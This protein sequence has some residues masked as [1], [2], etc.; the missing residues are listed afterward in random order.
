ME[1]RKQII[2]EFCA[3]PFID[4][5]I[6]ALKDN[7]SLFSVDLNLKPCIKVKKNRI[8]SYY[9]DGLE[10]LECYAKRDTCNK[11]VDKFIISIIRKCIKKYAE[12][13]E[14]EPTMRLDSSSAILSELL[15]ILINR[16]E[17]CREVD[18]LKFAEIFLASPYSHP[19]SL[20]SS[21]NKLNL[22]AIFNNNSFFNFYKLIIE[23]GTI[24]TECLKFL[25][26]VN[27]I[28]KETGFLFYEYS[29]NKIMN[30]D[31]YALCHMGAFCS[32]PDYVQYEFTN[33]DILV[34]WFK[35]SSKYI[36]FEQ[37]QKDINSFIKSDKY[38]LKRAGL[39]LIC[40]NFRT[41]KNI[42]YKNI[43]RFINDRDFYS[44]L[45]ELININLDQLNIE[46]VLSK[47]EKASFGVKNPTILKNHIYGI[48]KKYLDSDNGVIKQT[49][50]YK[51]ETVKDLNTIKNINRMIYFVEDSKLDDVDMLYKQ[52]KDKDPIQALDIYKNSK[53]KSSYY[54]EVFCDAYFQLIGNNY[55]FITD[56]LEK[57][58]SRMINQILFKFENSE[59][60]LLNL[61][62]KFIETLNDDSFF[63][64]CISTVLFRLEKLCDSKKFNDVFQMLSKIDYRKIEIKQEIKGDTYISDLINYNMHTYLKMVAYCAE[65]NTVY[66]SFLKDV[67]EYLLKVVVNRTTKALISYIMTRLSRID[68]N[69]CRSILD[70]V[71]DNT[72][73]SFNP[74]F[75]MYSISNDID[76]KLLDLIKDRDDFKKYIAYE[77]KNGDIQM[78]QKIIFS[79]LLLLA[80]KQK[81]FSFYDD[82]IKSN[83]IDCLNNGFE[84]IKYWIINNESAVEI[85]DVVN[86]CKLVNLNFN[87]F[88][89][90]DK[91]QID[92][93]IRNISDLLISSKKLDDENVW[94]LY[95][96]LFKYFGDYFSDETISVLK[97]YKTKRK[98]YI[99]KIM[100][101]YV[102]S[103][104]QYAT[105]E[106]TLIEA[107]SIFENDPNYSVELKRWK[108]MINNKNPYFFERR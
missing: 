25:A 69:Y 6:L 44:D 81:N 17:Y 45:K 104:E 103:Y 97:E 51:T 37:L 59:Q 85:N 60:K 106:P 48:L 41:C 64:D 3:S 22:S 35:E 96:T 107:L 74:S 7:E 8:S 62:Q 58:D 4:K 21:L 73:E 38:F 77:T 16:P 63:D 86:F 88:K 23:K 79:R 100:R 54:L 15:Q 82:Y 92:Q 66:F 32:Y 18:F 9:W 68:I 84:N 31:H 80:F 87:K 75:L 57:F 105:Y 49:I 70:I 46:L 42:F 78:S 40:I 93:L 43:D 13:D 34:L 90:I 36:S 26:D 1:K 30:F 67:I 11:E 2:K 65:C 12:D 5:W 55:G 101:K 50:N 33:K 108:I 28:N 89:N 27:L 39:A 83:N 56:N 52:I 19:Y 53:D 10:I 91:F 24:G 102:D 20:I 95:I 71:F 47:L 61:L 98:K 29:K 99:I 14:K 76:C 94:E 72:S